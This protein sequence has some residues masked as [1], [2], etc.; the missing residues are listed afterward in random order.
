MTTNLHSQ[1]LYAAHESGIDLAVID[2]TNPA[3][4]FAITDDEIA[5]MAERHRI[6][7]PQQAA[8]T[9][10]PEIQQIIQQ[11]QLWR[12]LRA[13]SGGFLAWM[14]TYVLKLGPENLG[15]AETSPIDR[16]IVASFPALALR[17][18]LQDMARLLT[19]GIAGMLNDAQQRPIRFINVAGGP[20]SDCW[21]ALI[22][23]QA[24]RPKLLAG[25]E[26]VIA[27]LD[28]DEAGPAFG[29]RAVAALCEPGAPLSGL[30][31]ALRHYPYQWSDTARLRQVLE[32]LRASEAACA[33]SSE[34]GLFEYG[35]DVD[36]VANLRVLHAGTAADA[37]VV[38]SV[39]RDSELVRLSQSIHGIRL[40]PRTIDAFQAL[41]AEAGWRVERVIERPMSY[42][43][44]LMKQ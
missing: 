43:V 24:E 25:L 23:L 10:T 33:I 35:T 34:G 32:E 20:A 17:I 3:F 38:G 27:V 44:L 37:V 36:V 22:V 40:Q 6:E 14:P 28:Q 41:S 29:G 31:V 1:I 42:H 11:S 15:A 9:I 18:R 13:A 16:N 21:N 26:I 2:I 19:D 30:D 12:S 8:A 5:A 7:L 39:T 4:R